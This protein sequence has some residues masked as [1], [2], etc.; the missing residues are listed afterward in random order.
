MISEVL[1]LAHLQSLGPTGAAALLLV[2]QDIF[3]DDGDDM[4]FTAWIDA[5][6]AN[7][8]AWARACQLWEQTADA[9]ELQALRDPP[10]VAAPQPVAP[11]WSAPRYAIAASIAVALVGGTTLLVR[12][13]TAPAA[14]QLA[15]AEPSMLLAT[16]HGERRSFTLPDTSSVTLNTDTVMR[17]AFHPGGE[18]RLELLRGQ[19]IFAVFHDRTRPFVV[20]VGQQTVTALGTHFEVRAEPNLM[21]VVLV[22]GSVAVRAGRA[23]RPPTILRPGEALTARGDAEPVVARADLDAVGDWQRGIVTF[24]DTPLSSAAA[25]IDRYTPVQLVIRDPK[26]A[27]Y[28]V[29]G[30]FHTDDTARFARTVAE[31]YPVRVIAA[32]SDRLEIVAAPPK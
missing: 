11:R 24:H 1:T 18:R 17:V 20:A 14:P 30:S 12:R 8:E 28:R 27:G 6:P 32:G 3:D 31:L 22:E 9:P 21:R 25:E 23:D 26:V 29:S 19:A 7:G 16:A 2:R 15:S 10:A 4:V 13:P 5:D